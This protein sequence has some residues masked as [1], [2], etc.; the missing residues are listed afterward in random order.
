[1]KG[2]AIA[3]KGKFGSFGKVRGT[4]GVVLE[5]RDQKKGFSVGGAPKK[6]G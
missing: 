2:T 5:P 3:E 1:M 6:V 4:R